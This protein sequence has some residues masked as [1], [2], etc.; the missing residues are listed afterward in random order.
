MNSTQY[1]KTSILC[2]HFK[3]VREKLDCFLIQ[4]EKELSVKII[5]T[6]VN[7]IH[8][9]YHSKS[10]RILINFANG[11]PNPFIQIQRLCPL[12]KYYHFHNEMRLLLATL[13]DNLSTL[14]FYK[15]SKQ[16]HKMWGRRINSF[17]AAVIICCLFWVVWFNILFELLTSVGLIFWI[18]P[19]HVYIQ[20]I[21]TYIFQ[22]FQ[23]YYDFLRV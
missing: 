10:K 22:L 17:L 4:M 20:Y 15:K 12:Q 13:K 19:S 3:Q 5:G 16:Q 21:C 11:N 18:K 23:L 9:V 8:C 1:T 7:D 6:T 14:N 2:S